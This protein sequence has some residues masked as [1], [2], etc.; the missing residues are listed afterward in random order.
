MGRPFVS[1]VAALAFALV[2]AA[3]A[4]AEKEA[5]ATVPAPEG[6][7]LEE[8]DPEAVAAVR[9]AAELLARAPR[10]SFRVDTEW[11]AVQPDGQK[12]EFGATRRV[13]LKRPSS[14]RF[15]GERRDGNRGG[16]LFDGQTITVWDAD[17]NVY[18][19]AP[20]TAD[21]DEMIDYLV[22]ELDH[23]LTLR[24]LVR[25]DLPERLTTGL[26]TAEFVGDVKLG[27][28]VCDQIALRNEHV[29][30]Q[31][32]ISQGPRPLFRRVVVNYR[33]DDGWPQFRANLSEWSFEPDV[34]D[35]KFR[36]VPPDGA[37]KIFFAPRKR[38]AREAGE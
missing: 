16:L 13:L 7:S 28:T 8:V 21:V 30:Y 22:D 35:A 12:I 14:L 10:L 18:A 6:E 23:P 1:I 19:T 3:P 27:D 15:E 31:L 4:L 36:F 17:E 2:L 34:A 29:D 26:R 32:W 25:S 24:Y 37:E 11:D 38:R 20:K 33:L 9:A 5:E